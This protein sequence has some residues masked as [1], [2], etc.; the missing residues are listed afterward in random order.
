MAA[1]GDHRLAGDRQQADPFLGE[2]GGRLVN[3]AK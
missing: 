1:D 3:A 2:F